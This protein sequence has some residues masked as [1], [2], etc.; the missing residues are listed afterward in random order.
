MS[1]P[2]TTECACIHARPHSACEWRI[3]IYIW[4]LPWTCMHCACQ[5]CIRRVYSHSN[6]SG[7]SWQLE[8]RCRF[9]LVVNHDKLPIRVSIRVSKHQ[10]SLAIPINDRS[11]FI[12]GRSWPETAGQLFANTRFDCPSEREPRSGSSP[13]GRSE[14]R[15][16]DPDRPGHP[17]SGYES[18]ADARTDGVWGQDTPTCRNGHA[19]KT[20]GTMTSETSGIDR[21]DA[22]AAAVG[23]EQWWWWSDA[24]NECAFTLAHAREHKCMADEK[25]AWTI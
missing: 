17:S 1:T 20:L 19:P 18:P 2:C 3:Y 12:F 10:T 21:M 13:A 24:L 14:W 7:G 5:A 16:R 25:Y 23:C 4:M 8:I 15:V 11:V 22:A 9:E 6:R